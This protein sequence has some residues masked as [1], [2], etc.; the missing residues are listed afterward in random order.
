MFVYE[1]FK[2]KQFLQKR[3][4]AKKITETDLLEI[5]KNEVKNELKDK[6]ENF[7]RS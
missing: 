4:K 6:E 5:F 3:D 2:K 7:K 1:Y